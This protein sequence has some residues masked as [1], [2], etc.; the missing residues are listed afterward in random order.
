MKLHLLDMGSKIYGDCIVVVEG[1]RKILI[2]GGHPG[3][4]K[5]SGS[6]RS[7]PDQLR[8]ILGP[9]PF[10]FDLLVVTHCHLDHIGCL[11]KLVKDG[12]IECEQALVADEDLGFPAG[13]GSDALDAE[14]AMLVAA[15][16]EEPQPDLR[17]PALDEFLAD[18]ASLADNYADMLE[19][20]KQNHTK[21]VRYTGPN[22]KINQIEQDFADFHL[23]VLGPTNA[24]LK[25]C[26]DALVG[27]HDAAV[28]A[29]DG[30]RRVDAGLSA[31]AL[32]ARMVSDRVNT[33]ASLPDDIR[34]A[35]DQTGSGAA[36]NDQSIVLKVGQ[37]NDSSL[38]TGDM[39]FAKS[40]V[41]GLDNNMQTL[42]QAIAAAGPYKF[43]KLPHHASYNG[44]DE[45]ILQIFHDTKAFGIS[46][47][48]GDP[49]H[50]QRDVLQL[51]R[52]VTDQYKWART[53][54]NGGFAVSFSGG[55]VNL[56]VQRGHLNDA[57]AN[58]PDTEETST[59]GSVSATSLAGTETT[60][61]I[62]TRV[63]GAD[64]VEIVARIPHVATR[65]TITVDVAPVGQAAP[66]DD[67]RPR[68]RPP[69]APAYTIAGGRPLPKLLFV[70]NRGR[71]NDNVG[72]T[73]AG[74]ALSAIQ[75]AGHPIVDLENAADGHARVREAAQQHSDIK[76]VVVL[77]G[78]DVV[79][80]ER[81]DTL[82]PSVR[83]QINDSSSDH[84][85]FIVWSDQVYGDVDGDGLA[86][87]PVS[88]IPDGRSAK[89]VRN[90]LSGVGVAARARNFGL[91]NVARPFAD[92]IY[93]IVA[94]NAPM[95]K[96]RPTRAQDV[97]TSAVDASQIYIMLH[98]SDVDTSRFWGEAQ[99]SMLEAMRVGTIPDPCGGVVFAGCCWGALT[100]RT[101]ASLYRA[102]DPLQA[103]T[104][105]QSVALS[106]LLR[107]A[108]AF[109]GCTGTHYSPVDG[110]Y[111]YFGGPM[112]TEF[113]QRLV[114]GEA[115]AAALFGAKIA[116][117]AGMP[118]NR[119]S[120]EEI[121]IENK[122][123]RQ[124]TCLGLGW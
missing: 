95:L 73:E 29:I 53:D 30:L 55:N 121:A 63:A 118:H 83:A 66:P 91:R 123:L 75:S 74:Q 112:H 97:D 25:K 40:E 62:V 78:Y 102:G 94:A 58:N 117:L 88:R 119:T 13:G 8:A 15:L 65:V 69:V 22:A 124:F 79:P 27:T 93:G 33:D 56:D 41:S 104:P 105:E 113:W 37:G 76:G 71:L 45:D 116:Y 98:G 11:P 7:I 34:A 68:P 122:I 82:P 38:L 49:K 12:I 42:V 67:R 10:K 54:K 1:S 100:V 3:D 96:S 48:R 80:A 89:L 109:V 51:L 77:G 52:S 81:Y 90:A 57:T 64:Q 61:P 92:T 9:P 86:D 99:G 84:D 120:V 21:I 60:R 46:T 70:T 101:R 23:K 110:N 111:N 24:H 108:R 28:I 39:Q 50:P 72:E 36:R 103:I 47:G 85:D 2:D 20:L 26:R 16:Q 44:F 115:P 35:L 14:T 114:A 5:A 43:V 107:G 31:A 59:S 17:G 4:W 32:Y 87:L 19:T 106:F 18:S 6:T